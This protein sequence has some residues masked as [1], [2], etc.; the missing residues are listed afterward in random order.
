MGHLKDIRLT[1]W[2]ALLLAVVSLAAT[3]VILAGGGDKSNVVLAAEI[4]L[5]HRPHV[6]EEV[7]PPAQ[8]VTVASPSGGSDVTPPATDSGSAGS[9]SS[10]DSGSTGSGSGD[11]TGSASADS[12]STGQSTTTAAATTT[13]AAAPDAGLPKVGHVFLLSLSTTDYRSAFGAKSAAPY[14]R[15]LLKKYGLWAGPEGEE[16]E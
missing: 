16:A 3:I 12:T 9:S 1:R 13:T 4:G 10:S 2:G 14:L 8:T 15:S 6:V 7:R 11:T 5:K